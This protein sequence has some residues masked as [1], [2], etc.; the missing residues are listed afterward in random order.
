[1][2]E[3]RRASIVCPKCGGE[4]SS[5]KDSRSFSGNYVWRRRRC[6]ICGNIYTTYEIP[7]ETI[8]KL[9]VFANIAN[10]TYEKI[11]NAYQALG[12]TIDCLKMNKT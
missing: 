5:I 10:A 12:D 8:D 11:G 4:R 7:C 1:M 2:G 3:M 6:A 9:K